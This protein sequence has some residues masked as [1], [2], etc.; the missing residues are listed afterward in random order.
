MFGGQAPG[1]FCHSAAKHAFQALASRPVLYSRSLGYDSM[2]KGQGMEHGCKI[3]TC[4]TGVSPV[5][6]VCQKTA[7]TW[8]GCVVTSHAAC[9]AVHHTCHT[10]VTL[11]THASTSMAMTVAASIAAPVAVMAAAPVAVAP[12]DRGRQVQTEAGR[13]RQ[14]QAGAD[15]GRQV[16]CRKEGKGASQSRIQVSFVLWGLHRGCPCKGGTQA[17]R[18]GRLGARRAADGDGCWPALHIYRQ[19]QQVQEETGKEGGGR[20]G[21]RAGQQVRL[22]PARQL[23]QEHM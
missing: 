13:C 20:E 7:G 15:R 4:N 22:G 14:R 21:V 2:A 10:S 11:T 5:W 6:V 19:L 8:A 23:G 1:R 17:R 3:T 12:A 16:Q 9:E 18:V